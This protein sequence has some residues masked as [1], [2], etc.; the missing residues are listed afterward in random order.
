M[1]TVMTPLGLIALGLGAL[2]V[3]AAVKGEHPWAA[4]AR[5]FGVDEPAAPG[6]PTINPRGGVGTEPYGPPSAGGGA[7]SSIP[8]ERANRVMAD[9]LRRFP[10]ATS[11]GICSCRRIRPHDGGTSSAWSPHAWC[12]AGDIGGSADTMRRVVVWLNVHRLT[13]GLV[14]II[15]PG[16]AVNSVHYDFGNHPGTPPCAANEAA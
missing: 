12:D 7:G 13:Y 14:N 3:N 10:G 11:L 6:G 15:P 16:S 5:A 1:S 4:P 2:F 9:V 8:S